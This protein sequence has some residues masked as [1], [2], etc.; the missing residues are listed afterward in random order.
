MRVKTN[1]EN[2]VINEIN[3]NS[4][5]NALGNQYESA[6]IKL[7]SQP[8]KLVILHIEQSDYTY[9]EI[10][11]TLL[12]GES[13]NMAFRGVMQFCI[14]LDISATTSARALKLG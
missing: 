11:L 5:L 13:L 10:S 7:S 4:H 3:I 14:T 6:P 8:E 9:R 2:F 12:R 1:V